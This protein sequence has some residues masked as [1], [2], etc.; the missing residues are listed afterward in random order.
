MAILPCPADFN[1]DLRSDPDDLADYIACY[2]ASPPCE[3]ADVDRSGSAD[4]DDL[5]DYIAAYFSPC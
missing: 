5:A 1:R 2:F 3:A 4:P